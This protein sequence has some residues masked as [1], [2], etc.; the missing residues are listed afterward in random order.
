[1]GGTSGRDE[2]KGILRKYPFFLL[3]ERGTQFSS[4]PIKQ[5]RRK[6]SAGKRRGARNTQ[7]NGSASGSISSKKKKRE[8]IKEEIHQVYDPREPVIIGTGQRKK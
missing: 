2:E 8:R 5:E 4:D 7:Q 6:M 3:L 1:M